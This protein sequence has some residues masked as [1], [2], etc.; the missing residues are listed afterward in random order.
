MTDNAFCIATAIGT[1]FIC[2][3]A[4]DGRTLDKVKNNRHMEGRKAIA[5]VN[6]TMWAIHIFT[7]IN[8]G[9]NS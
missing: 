9:S 7:E 4:T 6:S 3:K 5:L 8:Y 1:A 2:M